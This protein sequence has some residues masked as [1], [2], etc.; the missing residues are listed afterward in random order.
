[1]ACLGVFL[2]IPAQYSDTLGEGNGFPGV[3]ASPQAQKAGGNGRSQPQIPSGILHHPGR[4]AENRVF[5]AFDCSGHKAAGGRIQLEHP[6][7]R[8]YPEPLAAVQVEGEDG[9]AQPGRIPGKVAVGPESLPVKLEQA[10]F[11]P[12]PPEPCLVLGDTIDPVGRK[13]GIAV[14]TEKRVWVGQT[15]PLCAQKYCGQEQQ[16]EDFERF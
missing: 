4:E 8:H 3:A 2:D 5:Y 1:M 15:I 13:P 12:K 9:G 7:I 16:G 10:G 6:E 11:R 14:K